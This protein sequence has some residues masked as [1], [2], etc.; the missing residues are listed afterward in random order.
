MNREMAEFIRRHRYDDPSVLLLR[1]S[2]KNAEGFRYADAV[3]QIVCRRKAAKKIP[4]FIGHED[5]MF[6]DIVSSEQCTDER[7][8]KFH[9]RLVGTDERVLDMTAGLGIDSMTIAGHCRSVTAIELDR[10]KADCL[11]Y[12]SKVAGIT[13]LEVTNADSMEWLRGSSEHFDTIFIDPSRRKNNGTRTYAL[14]DC[15]PD[16]TSEAEMML[17]HCGRIIVKASPMLD[18]S[19][20][21]K[22]LKYA[23]RIFTVCS[24]GECKELLAELKYGDSDIGIVASDIDKGLEISVTPTELNNSNGVAYLSG[25]DVTKGW[26]LYEPNAALMKLGCWSAIC[27]MFPAMMKAGRNTHM[28]FSREKYPDF[29]GRILEIVRII[30]KQRRKDIKGVSFNVA[31]RNFPLSA[32]GLRRRLQLK[33]GG[34]DFIYGIGYGDKKLLIEC[35]NLSMAKHTETG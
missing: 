30:D 4:W 33:D 34:T 17:S 35:R 15:E 12:N 6:P 8:A 7:V 25:T 16:I 5:F 23:N 28:F 31:V 21:I 11:R 9:A 22:D 26:Y 14:K 29:P 1:Y 2:D 20:T 27:R 18:I 24:S 13:N 3:T 19:Q 32:D 10:N